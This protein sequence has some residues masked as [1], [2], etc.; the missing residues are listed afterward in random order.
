[1]RWEK[2]ESHNRARVRML[3]TLIRGSSTPETRY[4]SKV[5]VSWRCHDR[6]SNSFSFGLFTSDSFRKTGYFFSVVVQINRRPQFLM[7]MLGLPG[8]R[9]AERQRA[10][11]ALYDPPRNTRAQP[12]EA[13]G[14]SIGG[15]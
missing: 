7:L 5:T 8:K 12:D 14:G 15:D 10:T 13:P 9:L 6:R 4:R 1:M 11:L 3:C 2:S